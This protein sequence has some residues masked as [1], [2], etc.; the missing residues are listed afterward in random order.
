MKIESLKARYPKIKGIK[1]EPDASCGECG[2]T[3]ISPAKTLRGGHKIG[4]GPC[5]CVFMGTNTKAVMGGL[6]SL[7]KP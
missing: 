5:A 4:D 1:Y 3:G 7:K 6:K 2:G